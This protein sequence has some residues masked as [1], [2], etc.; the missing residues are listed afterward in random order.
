MLK[1]DVVAL[2]PDQNLNYCS[3]EMD[4]THNVSMF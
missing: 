1:L 3:V 2:R 4:P